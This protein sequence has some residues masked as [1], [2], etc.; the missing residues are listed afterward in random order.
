MTNIVTIVA[1]LELDLGDRPIGLGKRLVKVWAYSVHRQ[2]PA[3]IGQYLPIL[4]GR[5]SM[6]HDCAH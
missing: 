5:S 2:H 1:V 3:P 4:E 6:E